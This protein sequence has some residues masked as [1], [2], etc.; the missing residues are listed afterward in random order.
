MQQPLYIPHAL[1]KGVSLAT[2]KV[3]ITKCITTAPISFLCEIE[4]K[5]LHSRALFMSTNQDIIPAKYIV[6][7]NFE[8]RG[9][10]SADVIVRFLSLLNSR[11]NKI[12]GQFVASCCNYFGQ[13][14]EYTTNTTHMRK[15][16]S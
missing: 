7:H 12:T 3:L 6:C 4:E 5:K 8:K 2:E 1:A 15:Y 11:S 13:Y 10:D 16:D 9:D 14:A